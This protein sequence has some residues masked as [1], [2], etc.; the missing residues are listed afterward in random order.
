MHPTFLIFHSTISRQIHQIKI[1]I[2]CTR[3]SQIFSSELIFF[4]YPKIIRNYW[5]FF[6]IFFPAFTKFSASNINLNNYELIQGSKI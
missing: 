6:H 2:G 3:F 1:I 5:N 4:K